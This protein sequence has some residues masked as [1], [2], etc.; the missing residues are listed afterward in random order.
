MSLTQ[1]YDFVIQWHLTERCNLR[2]RHCYQESGAGA[3]LPFPEI[4]EVIGEIAR[5]FQVWRESYDIEF[6]PSFNVTGGEPFLRADFFAVLEEIRDA[7]FTTYVLS[8]GTV[9]TPERAARLAALGVAGVQVSLEG[10]EA[11]HDSIRGL[12]SFAASVEGIK[13]LLAAGVPVSVNS[14][15]SRL[16][17]D[18]FLELVE[19]AAAL[20]VPRLGFSRLVP[21]GRGLEMLGQMLDTGQV[22]QFYEKIFSLKIDGLEIV[23]GDPMA[24]QMRAASE[25]ADL[26]D[27]PAG[28][29]A[30]GIAGLTILADG[31]LTPCRRLPI[32]LGR[33]GRDSLRE[34][35]AAAPVLEALRD[36]RRYGG[37]CGA[38]RRWADCRG[39]RAIAYAY[40]LS[41]GEDDYLAPDPQCF[42]SG[43]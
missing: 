26:G 11:I 28:G 31:T 1:E 13:E 14:T 42:I 9:V 12:H 36:R 3:E 17:A 21:S 22:R 6:S 8:N 20:R 37:K 27:I 19:V 33:A 40:S 5:M 2:C 7:G 15:L 35:W 23:T 41:R 29:C 43:Q 34:L 39:C 4:R 10:P 38:C 24:A 18:H 30:A 32:P 16:N 25:T